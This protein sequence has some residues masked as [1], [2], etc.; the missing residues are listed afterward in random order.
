M[1]GT[2]INSPHIFEHEINANVQFLH[3]LSKPSTSVFL[4]WEIYP[5]SKMAQWTGEDQT[6]V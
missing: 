3:R 5:F 6:H 2:E 1:Q 4:K